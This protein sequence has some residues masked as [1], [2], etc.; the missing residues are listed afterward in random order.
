MS[1]VQQGM[2]P[3]AT[4][5]RQFFWVMFW[6]TI[7]ILALLYLYAEFKVQGNIARLAPGVDG[8]VL[9]SEDFYREWT[10]ALPEVFSEIQPAFDSATG[11][12]EQRIST[13]LLYTSDAADDLYTV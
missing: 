9:V 7:L 2:D 13:C 5:P 12:M 8:R 11:E 6:A 10:T 1:R 3:A 4:T